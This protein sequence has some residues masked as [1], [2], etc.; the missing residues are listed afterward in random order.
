LD[1]EK[2]VKLQKWYAGDVDEAINKY[3]KGENVDLRI[4]LG[5]NYYV[6]LKTGYSLIHIRRWFLPENEE[7]VRPTRTGIALNFTQWEKLK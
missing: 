2:W 3:Q 7:E 4:H 1:L 6:S 5:R